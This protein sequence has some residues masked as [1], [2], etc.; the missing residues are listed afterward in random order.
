MTLILS[1]SFRLQHQF[2]FSPSEAG[3]AIGIWPLTMMVVAPLSGA[4]SDRYPAGLLG[5]IGMGIGV[6]ALLLIAFMPAQP[7]YWDVAWRMAF[8]GSGSVR[9]SPE[10]AARLRA[11]L[12]WP[13]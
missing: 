9:R 12:P 5:A 6:I 8:A 1:M 11:W 4:L 3:A 10:D 7:D 13:Q 2:G